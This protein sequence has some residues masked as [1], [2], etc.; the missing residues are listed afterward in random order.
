MTYQ[1][2][3]VGAAQFNG[4]LF[5]FLKKKGLLRNLGVSVSVQ[6]AIR[7]RSRV[8]TQGRAQEFDT[9][10]SRYNVGIKYRVPLGKSSFVLSAGYDKMTH[11]IDSGGVALDL[12]NVS[13]SCLDA[14]GGLRIP[15]SDGKMAL[16]AS[17]RYLHVL[18]AGQITTPAAYGNATIQG[19]DVDAHLIYMAS[20]SLAIRGGVQFV[21]MGFAFDGSG[22]MTQLDESPDQDVGGAADTWLGG[23]VTAGLVF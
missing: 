17:G 12:P 14:G 19:L 13:Y 6:K 20:D 18:D 7:L 11:A 2:T 16:G 22:A 4:E 10:Q 1:G 8:A 15:V 23:Y 21:R 5:P 3:P 9:D